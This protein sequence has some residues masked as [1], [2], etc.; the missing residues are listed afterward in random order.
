MPPPKSPITYVRRPITRSTSS[1]GKAILHDTHQDLREAEII[2]QETLLNLQETQK[3]DKEGS[4][5]HETKEED[6]ELKEPSP[7]PNLESYYRFIERGRVI[8]Q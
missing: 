4:L 2:L 7:Q 3:L 1:K 5:Q 6:L 8:P